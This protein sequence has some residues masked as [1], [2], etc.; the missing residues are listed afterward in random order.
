VIKSFKHDGVERFFKTE[1]RAGIQPKHAAR[2]KLQ[3]SLLNAAE[4]AQEMNLPGWDWHPLKGGLA[5]HWAV[6]VNGDWRL[7]FSFEGKDAVL[8]DYQDYH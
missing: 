7:T 5:G 2:L 8:V 1:S 6:K 4:S 3:L